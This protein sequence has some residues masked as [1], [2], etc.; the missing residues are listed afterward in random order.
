MFRNESEPLRLIQPR[1][2]IFMINGLPVGHV[3]VDAQKTGFRTVRTEMD[4]NVGEI[5]LSIERGD[6]GSA[7]IDASQPSKPDIGSSGA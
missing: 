1:R 7:S 6:C 3:V 2:G 5:P 4:L